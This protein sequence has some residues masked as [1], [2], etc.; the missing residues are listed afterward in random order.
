MDVNDVRHLIRGLLDEGHCDPRVVADEVFSL[1]PAEDHGQIL[2]FVLGSVAKDVL[3][4]RRQALRRKSGE[5]RGPYSVS[6]PSVGWVSLDQLTA[7]QCDAI[8]LEYETRAEKNLFYAN[9]YRGLAKELRR[10]GLTYVGDLPNWRDWHSE[11]TK[12]GIQ[13]AKDRGLTLGTPNRASQVLVNRV[14]DLY[15]DGLSLQQIADLLN[16]EGV[17][18]SMSGKKWY[19]STIRSILDRSGTPRRPRNGKV[20][21]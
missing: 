2:K 5:E 20:S 7:E 16:E 6:V 17:P 11:Q 1:I 14:S 18:T 15:V 10:E 8:A 9:R 21:A 19:S 4:G 3:R 12:V 13:E